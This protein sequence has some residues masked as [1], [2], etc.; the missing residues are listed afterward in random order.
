MS[1]PAAARSRTM[2]IAIILVA[3]VVVGTLAYFL[4]PRQ[5]PPVAEYRMAVVLGGDETDAGW[6]SMAIAGADSIREKYKWQVDISRNVPFPDQARVLTDYAQR[7]YTLVWAHGGQFIGDTIFGDTA[8]PRRF[9]S[10]F[11]AQIPGPGQVP[12]PPNTVSLGPDFQVTGFYLAGVLAGRMTQTNAVAVVIGQWFEY[13]S[14]EFYAFEAGVE[15][16]NANAKVYARVAGTWGDP[17]LGFQIAKTLIETKNVDILVH[18]ADATGRGVITAAEQLGATV[19]G[20]VGDQAVLAP[21][22]MMT[23]IMMDTP[24]FMESVVLSIMNGTFLQTMGGR[25]VSRDLGFLAPFH[26]FENQIPQAV[27]DLLV[28]VEADIGD[29]TVAVPR[30]VTAEPPPD[31]P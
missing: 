24:G 22:A 10:T 4:Y 3:I 15:S 7:G 16:V 23:S 31:P 1:S 25:V 12:P 28:S 19:I 9:N 30:T 2:W 5:A 6:S 18:V 14:M 29:G 21:D 13:L 26:R 11:F 8:V 20:T 17:S 27:K